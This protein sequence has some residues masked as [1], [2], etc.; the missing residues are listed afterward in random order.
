MFSDLGFAKQSK[1][2][3]Y[4]VQGRNGKGLKTFLWAK[5]NANGNF[6]AAAAIFDKPAAYEVVTNSGQIYPVT[7]AEL[8]LEER[9]SKG[10]Q[11]VPAMLGDFV[12]EVRSI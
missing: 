5:G 11:L 3:E 8:P 4:D 6:L 10:T 12:K 2:S 7:S 9:Y 1:L